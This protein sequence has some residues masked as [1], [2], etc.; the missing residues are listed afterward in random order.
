MTLISFLRESIMNWS[1]NSVIS[2]TSGMLLW[3]TL[4]GDDFVG[5]DVTSLVHLPERAC[6][7]VVVRGV[8]CVVVDDDLLLM[9]KIYL[10]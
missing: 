5:L 7:Q 2:R 6:S 10:Q 8:V 1:R 3:F 4:D 9:H